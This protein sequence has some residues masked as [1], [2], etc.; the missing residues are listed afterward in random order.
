MPLGPD[1][2]ELVEHF[3]RPLVAG[4]TFSDFINAL[5]GTA[6]AVSV[7]HR[8]DNAG[9]AESAILK[10]NFAECPRSRCIAASGVDLAETRTN[11]LFHIILSPFQLRP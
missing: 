10:L 7:R 6:T 1:G 11:D 2:A 9:D 3:L 4:T 5:A 8:A